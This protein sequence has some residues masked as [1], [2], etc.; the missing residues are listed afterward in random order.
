MVDQDVAAIERLAME[1]ISSLERGG[2]REIASPFSGEKSSYLKESERVMSR[3]SPSETRS[4]PLFSTPRTYFRSSY[5]DGQSGYGYSTT[6]ASQ[7]SRII[8]AIYRKEPTPVEEISYQVDT[9]EVAIT[10]MNPVNSPFSFG[11]ISRSRID[12]KIVLVRVDEQGEQELI[13]RSA[14]NQATADPEKVQRSIQVGN[15][16]KTQMMAIF[17]SS[18]IKVATSML[19]NWA[20][21]RRVPHEIL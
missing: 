3:Y 17:M 14:R 1:Q 4:V 21:E 10:N 18:L 13:S 19:G 15:E 9:K 2:P 11:G 6:P 7:F 20:R 16:M 5:Y 12:K 8:S